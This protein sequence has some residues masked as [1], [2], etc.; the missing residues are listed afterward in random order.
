MRHFVV[1]GFQRCGTTTLTLLADEHP[2]IRMARPF[3][4]EPKFFL[5]PRSA[6]DYP[7]YL[8][9][10]FA[11]R[12]EETVL[13]EKSTSYSDE[14]SVPARLECL[15]PGFR[16]VFLLRDPIARALSNYSFSRDNGLEDLDLGKVILGAV[17]AQEDTPRQRA[18]ALV[19]YLAFS[20]ERDIPATVVE[21]LA[22][23]TKSI[24]EPVKHTEQ[25]HSAKA[26]NYM[27]VASLVS[28]LEGR[29]NRGESNR[30]IVAYSRNL[31]YSLLPNALV[32]TKPH[33]LH[34]FLEDIWSRLDLDNETLEEPC[35]P[36][37]T[38]K[39][40]SE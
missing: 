25:V 6:E 17:S 19:S 2:A 34:K 33:E 15:L 40:G 35:A 27:E 13:G 1:P 4:P 38:G 36:P 3:R 8:E 28:S 23:E 26:K 24:L 9:R 32:A 16:A 12:G 10:F 5:S 31:L 22:R 7:A 14:L 37:G 11:A 30:L 20:R 21:T 39:G 18:V 29:V